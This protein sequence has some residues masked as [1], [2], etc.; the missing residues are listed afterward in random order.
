M[1]VEFRQGL[2]IGQ[3]LIK[4]LKEQGGD[5]LSATQIGEQK[6]VFVT[7]H[8]DL[9]KIYINPR[10]TPKA[11]GI[12]LEHIDEYGNFNFKEYTGIEAQILQ[13]Q[14]EHLYVKIKE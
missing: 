11:D 13:K 4:V 3:Y 14:Y 8:K 10:L 9:Y 7:F 12:F 6:S 1:E 2:V 5:G